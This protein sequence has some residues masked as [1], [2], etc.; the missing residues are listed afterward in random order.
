VDV[1]TL[2]LSP[3]RMA[4]SD[5]PPRMAAS[6]PGACTWVDTLPGTCLYLPIRFSTWVRLKPR[7]VALS[8]SV[9]IWA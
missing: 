9:P 2:P 1:A 6:S 4:S 8:M 5:W 7:W 3:F